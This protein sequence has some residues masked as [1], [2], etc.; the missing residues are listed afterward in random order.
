VIEFFS[1]IILVS[2]APLT[3][4]TGFAHAALLTEVF[5]QSNITGIRTIEDVRASASDATV[6]M[7]LIG[8]W[9]A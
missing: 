9:T 1:R 8:G 6:A 2:E 4:T 3:L 7:I 5:P